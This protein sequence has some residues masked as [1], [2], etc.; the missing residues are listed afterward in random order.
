MFG[1]IDFLS[2]V[3]T[4]LELRVYDHKL[5][6]SHSKLLIVTSFVVRRWA[7]GPSEKNIAVPAHRHA[8][9]RQFNEIFEQPK[10]FRL[11]WKS[12]G[13]FPLGSGMAFPRLLTGLATGKLFTPNSGNLSCMS[14]SHCLYT[15]EG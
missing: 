10:G 3:P 1:L 7:H 9:N 4:S 13:S 6:V 11:I 12:Q 15:F 5:Y 14:T 8:H 2:K